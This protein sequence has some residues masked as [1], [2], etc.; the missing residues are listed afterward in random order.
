MVREIVATV[1]A[2]RRT[3]GCG[4]GVQTPAGRVQ[5]VLQ[6]LDVVG[7]F[8]PVCGDRAKKTRGAPNQPG[9]GRAFPPEHRA[10]PLKG[11]AFPLRQIWLSHA[12]IFMPRLAKTYSPALPVVPF[13]Q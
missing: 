6:L 5:L 11:R 1:S 9:L 7:E 3:V 8:G 2:C 13:G 4:S 12:L 10:F